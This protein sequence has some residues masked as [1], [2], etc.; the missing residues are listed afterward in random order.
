MFDMKV[1]AVN[2]LEHVSKCK[3]LELVL[4][5]VVEAEWGGDDDVEDELMIA[6]V[7]N[8]MNK[9]PWRKL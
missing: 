9:E 6:G 7:R 8:A 1:D 2:P 4:P 3:Q 5:N